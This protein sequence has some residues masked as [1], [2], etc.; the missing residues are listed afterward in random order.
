MI[1]INRNQDIMV[2]MNELRYKNVPSSPIE[3]DE[4]AEGVMIR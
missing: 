3:K 2:W 1:G 4:E